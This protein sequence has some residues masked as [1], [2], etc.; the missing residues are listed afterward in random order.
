MNTEFEKQEKVSILGREHTKVESL[1]GEYTAYYIMHNKKMSLHRSDGK[2][3]FVTSQGN[4][5]FH[6]F[7]ESVSEEKALEFALSEKETH[8]KQKIK[9]F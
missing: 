2:P 9:D 4:Q 3:A 5:E 1:Q 8:K 6:L 7:G